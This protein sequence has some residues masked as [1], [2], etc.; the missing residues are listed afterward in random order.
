MKKY[1]LL[2][3]LLIPTHPVY[4]NQGIQSLPPLDTEG[5]INSHIRQLEYEYLMNHVDIETHCQQIGSVIANYRNSRNAGQAAYEKCLAIKR[6]E[7]EDSE[8]LNRPYQQ[9]PPQQ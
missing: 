6:K 1:L 7:K 5:A 8:T 9:Q 2:A 3:L 4:A